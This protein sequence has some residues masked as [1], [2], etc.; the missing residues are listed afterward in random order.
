MDTPPSRIAAKG[1]KRVRAETSNALDAKRGFSSQELLKEWL[2]AESEFVKSFNL[3][4]A[5]GGSR[6]KPGELYVPLSAM[7]RLRERIRFA[8]RRHALQDRRDS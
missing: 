3:S 8:F 2:A 1:K 5:P 7:Q 4:I 6:L